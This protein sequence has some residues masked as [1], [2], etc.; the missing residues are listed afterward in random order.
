LLWRQEEKPPPSTYVV[1]NTEATRSS[2]LIN[3]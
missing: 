3:D 1:P 2:F